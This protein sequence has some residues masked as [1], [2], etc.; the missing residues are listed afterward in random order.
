MDSKAPPRPF[1]NHKRC[2]A[3]HSNARAISFLKT[4]T[5]YVPT[6]NE[7]IRSSRTYSVIFCTLFGE[8]LQADCLG[9]SPEPTC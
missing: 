8:Y 4:A 9:N 1:C 6:A 7:T 3:D 2:A 5:M